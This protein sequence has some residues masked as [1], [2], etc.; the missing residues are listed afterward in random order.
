MEVTLFNGL[1]DQIN[2]AID[3]RQ[4]NRTEKEIAELLEIS[5][6]ALANLR[7][8]SYPSAQ[9]IFHVLKLLGYRINIVK[10]GDGVL[11]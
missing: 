10:R 1:I 8:R 3:A 2:K 7:G 5:S 4:G 9:T 6:T 11:D